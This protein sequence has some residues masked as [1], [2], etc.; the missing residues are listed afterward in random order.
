MEVPMFIRDILQGRRVQESIFQSLVLESLTISEKAASLLL[1]QGLKTTEKNKLILLSLRGCN[2]ADCCTDKSLPLPH[3]N[4]AAC[5]ARGLQENTTLTYLDLSEVFWTD[6][7]LHAILTALIGHPTLESIDLEGASFGSQSIA[8]L[9]QLLGHSDCKVKH[10]NLR[11]LNFLSEEN[12]SEIDDPMERFEQARQSSLDGPALIDALDA[13]HSL[14]K[15]FLLENA[16]F[17]FE[18]NLVL[19]IRLLRKHP[20]L[21]HMDFDDVDEHLP[22][23]IAEEQVD[24]FRAPK[25]SLCSTIRVLLHHNR[26]GK[27]FLFPA[28]RG[29][30]PLSAWPWA[31]ARVNRNFRFPWQRQEQAK[32]LLSFVKAFSGM[33]GS[34][35]S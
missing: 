15:I 23:G 17:F 22:E 19:F 21:W 14:Q 1:E 33:P 8:V 32:E 10:L 31:M 34:L 27:P 20:H 12:I 25:V 28:S 4:P 26:S 11:Q 5:L 13:S 6:R 7:Q 24:F 3:D 35:A 30:I 18:T 16:W 2:F 29:D 9:K